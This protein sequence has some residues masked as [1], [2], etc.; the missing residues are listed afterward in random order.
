MAGFGWRNPF[1]LE[2]GGGPTLVERIYQGLRAAVG[3][4]G[5]AQ[6]EDGSIDGVWRQARAL[7]LAAAAA[8]DER[9]AVNFFPGSATDLL[10]YYE[11][12]LFLVPEDEANLPDRRDAA[13]QAYTHEVLS[14]VPAVTED[15]QRID[16]RF[17]IIEIP[18]D[19]A[20]ETIPAR[21]FEDFAATLPFNG[22]RKSTRFPN[23]STEF[24]LFVLFDIGSGVD[25]DPVDALTLRRA[26]DYLNPALAGWVNFQISTAD[27]FILN[28]SLLDITG[29]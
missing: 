12:L 16:S 28:E 15:L 24:V 4:G 2:L 25:L 19:E 21:A 5:S 26:V 23:Y 17:S 8:A 13:E 3:E 27:G 1:P 9:A 11:E 14:S 29:L 10:Q 18:H 20:I 6:D 7:G 22:G